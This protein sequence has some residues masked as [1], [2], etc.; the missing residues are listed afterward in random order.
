M[1]KFTKFSVYGGLIC[2]GVGFLLMFITGFIG[3]ASLARDLSISFGDKG[4]WRWEVFD[5]DAFDSM[6]DGMNKYVLPSYGDQRFSVEE[7]GIRS[8]KIAVKGGELEIVR[9]GNVSDG[10]ILV[11]VES[12]RKNWYAIDHDGTLVIGADAY[13][14]KGTYGKIVIDLGIDVDLEKVEVNLGG[15]EARVGSLEADRV[16]INLGAGEME[17]GSITASELFVEVG[18]GELTLPEVVVAEKINI[19]VGVGELDICIAEESRDIDIKCG[20][21]EVTCFLAGEDALQDYNYDV[22]CGAGEITIGNQNMGGVGMHRTIDNGASRTVS[23]DCG[24]GEVNIL[25]D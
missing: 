18:A 14:K 1:K 20:M 9:T 15:G 11:S 6:F 10:E 25:E 13:L 2:L 17:I 3:G 22:T 21:G 7:D 12:S 19:D 24:M 23:V 16:E 8:L 5:H 4:I